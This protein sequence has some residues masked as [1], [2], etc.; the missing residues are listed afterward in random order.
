[1]AAF[2]N[3][4]GRRFGR[5]LVVEV[6]GASPDGNYRWICR[7]DCGTEKDVKSQNL[8]NGCSKSCGCLKRDLRAARNRVEH[9]THGLTHSRAFSIW[10]SMIKRCYNKN[11][12]YFHNYG[13]R[14]ILMC[15]SWRNS[16]ENF[17]L[18]MGHPPPEMSIDRIDNAKGYS[19]G[20]CRWATRKEQARNSRRN[21]MLTVNG[22]TKC[23]TDWAECSHNTVARISQRLK[24]G[25]AIEKAIF[26]PLRD[27]K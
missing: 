1:M 11:H 16:F 14:G 3:L 2:L 18:D 13:G 22:E 15:D 17:L 7:C 8:M 26:N 12:Q 20:N 21:R 19:N 10:S 25:W 5:W 4:T 23:L 27:A 6:F 24:A 9:R